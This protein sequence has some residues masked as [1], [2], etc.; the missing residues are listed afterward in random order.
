VAGEL[1]AELG[2]VVR[3]ASGFSGDDIAR[4]LVRCAALSGPLRCAE[5][6]DRLFAGNAK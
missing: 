1:L 6:L 5:L 4:R 2:G 3:F